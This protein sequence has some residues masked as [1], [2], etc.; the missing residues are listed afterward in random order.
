MSQLT[1]SITKNYL[2]TGFGIL[3]GLPVLVL[4]SFPHLSDKWKGIIGVL[5][6]IGTIG[7]GIVAKAFNVSSTQAEVD[8]ATALEKKP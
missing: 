3:A 2:T 5:G 7:L 8:Q 4:A 6:G 1:S